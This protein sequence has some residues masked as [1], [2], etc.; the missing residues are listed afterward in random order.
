MR[1]RGLVLAALA[2]TIGFGAAGPSAASAIDD[3][4]TR[5]TTCARFK[6]FVG[7]YGDKNRY[8]PFYGQKKKAV[9]C[10][11][12]PPAPPPPVPTPPVTK[13]QPPRKPAPKPAPPPVVR[14]PPVAPPAPR[15]KAS[16]PGARVLIVDKSGRGDTRTIADAVARAPANAT[17]EIRPGEY[18]ENVHLQRPV[19][20]RGIT[21]PGGVRPII[22]S[23]TG[24]AVLLVSGADVRLESLRFRATGGQHNAIYVFGG[25][26]QA[27][28]IEASSAP[29]ADVT[30]TPYGTVF[31][32]EARKVVLE[33]MD[34]NAHPAS[35]SGLRLMDSKD[36]RLDNALIA[37]PQASNFAA[38]TANRSSLLV[39]NS[40]LVSAIALRAE[41]SSSISVEYSVFSGLPNLRA[42]AVAATGNSSVVVKSG[43][44]CTKEAWSRVDGSSAI[45]SNGLYGTDG[46]L[47]SERNTGKENYS[48]DARRICAGGR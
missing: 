28:D 20:L 37:F 12:D 39:R 24:S 14:T 1:H 21:G 10:P 7:R 15:P 47:L 46:R 4:W 11:A 48:Q 2:A 16:A 44:L 26:L 34:I 3:E 29:A 27:K 6:A 35:G 19:T 40:K 42:D 5:A 43:V 45:V 13:P 17:I 25:S 23:S 8:A 32:R 18:R 33:D 30:V 22:I 41:E 36:V 31:I 9:G 38:V